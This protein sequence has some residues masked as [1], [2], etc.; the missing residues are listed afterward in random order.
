MDVFEAVRTLLAVR[1]YRADPVPDDVLLRILEAGRLTGSASNRQ[2]W[3]FI[4]VQDQERIRE[5]AALAPSGPYLAGAPLAIV[6][7]TEKTLFGLS[8]ASRAIQSMMLTAWADG[9][10]SN[11]VGFAGM[12]QL[13]AP[14][15]IPDDLDAIGIVPF[16]YPAIPLGK[17]KKTRKPLGEIAHRERFGQ[18]F[19]P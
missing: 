7:A 12:D 13:K 17:G 3:H 18:P 10:G 11:W 19:E 9:V 16:G 15:G 2:P 1:Q 4:V 6:V 5:L 8:D 14:L